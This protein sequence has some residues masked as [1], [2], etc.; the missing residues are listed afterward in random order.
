MI[1]DSYYHLHVCKTGGRWFAETF[2][3]DNLYTHLRLNKKMSIINR[4][5]ANDDFG[6]TH[7]GWHPAI[8]S[9]TYIVSGIREP[10]SQICSLFVDA[11]KIKEFDENIKNRFLREIKDPKS[12]LYKNNQSKHFFYGQK[13]KDY[14]SFL[15]ASGEN[16]EEVCIERANRVDYFY[17]FE[18]NMNPKLIMSKMISDLDIDKTKFDIWFSYIDEKN[19]YIGKNNASK[20]LYESLSLEEK[21]EI[22]NNLADIDNKIYKIALSKNNLVN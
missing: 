21:N 6:Y 4:K 18:E 19:E 16:Y 2:L 10:V 1:Y 14:G 5:I 7:F 13:I 11:R 15:K 3:Y 8:N 17:V 12:N 22:L 9:S 20:E